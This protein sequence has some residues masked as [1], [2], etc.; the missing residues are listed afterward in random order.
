[1]SLF[2]FSEKHFINM[3][4]T[5]HCL[6]KETTIYT[7]HKMVISNHIICML[8]TVSVYIILYK[9]LKYLCSVVMV[10]YVSKFM[11]N[12]FYYRNE[13][14]YIEDLYSILWYTGVAHYTKYISV[15]YTHFCIAS[16]NYYV[17]IVYTYMYHHFKRS[18]KL[19]PFR[20]IILTFRKHQAIGWLVVEYSL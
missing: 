3:Y 1:M 5:M 7:S 18:F 8:Y 4:K 17:C 20:H 12:T 11:L 2:F 14:P 19:N 16:Q 6:S 13:I 9:S 15:S 10:M